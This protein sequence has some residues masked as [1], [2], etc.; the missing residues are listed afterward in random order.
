MK[1]RVSLGTGFL[2]AIFL[3][4]GCAS[5]Q[6]AKEKPFSTWS[7]KKKMTYAMKV[8]QTEYDK[9]MAAVVRPDLTEG[10]KEYLKQKRSA[11]V[12]LDKTIQALIPVVEAGGQV[13]PN[14]ESELLALLGDLGVHPM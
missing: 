7:S 4:V 13:P 6:M 9:Y 11:L 10:Q 8:Y 3:L 5:F 14:L 12:G 1:K 2:L